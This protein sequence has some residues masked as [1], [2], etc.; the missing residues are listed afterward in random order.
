MRQSAF[1]SG[2]V[3]SDLSSE[4]SRLTA[5]YSQFVE[6][7]YGATAVDLRFEKQAKL[8]LKGLPIDVVATNVFL[9][10]TI[11]S[12]SDLRSSAGIVAKRS[13]L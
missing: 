12:P 7:P 1:R 4:R 9:S 5:G 10:Y 6:A 3:D 13:N 2:S 11:S 8:S